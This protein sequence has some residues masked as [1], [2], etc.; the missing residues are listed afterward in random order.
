LAPFDLAKSLTKLKSWDALPSEAGAK[1]IQPLSARIL[2]PKN[3][4]TKELNGTHL[5]VFFLQRRIQPLQAQ[6]SKLWTYSGTIDPSR[7][8]KKDPTTKD[9]KKRVR[10]MTKLTAK[11]TVPACLAAPFD[12]KNI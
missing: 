2:E 1:E 9:L 3:A 4:T 11:I 8:S 10:S 5:V 6:I 7:V 12:A